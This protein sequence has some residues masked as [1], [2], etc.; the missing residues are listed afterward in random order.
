MLTR[1]E[2]GVLHVVALSGGHDSTSMSFLLR[3][4][5]PRPYNYV[6][7]PT[8]NEL[9]AM[10]EFSDLVTSQDLQVCQ[11]VQRNLEAGVYQGGVLS[12]KH[13]QGVAWFQD[14]I[15]AGLGLPQPPRLAAVG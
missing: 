6:C 4:R 1:D 8:G 14:R 11:E 10:F 5:E 9:P 7:T 13:E 15:A 2:N 3:Q 12:P